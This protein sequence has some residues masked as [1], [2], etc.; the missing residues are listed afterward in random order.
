MILNK[1][2][3]FD[4]V[5]LHC[6]INGFRYTGELVK[7]LL[8]RLDEEE[9]EHLIPTMR[10]IDLWEET[11]EIIEKYQ[12]PRGR[13]EL[14]YKLD[15]LEEQICFI[16]QAIEQDLIPKRTWPPSEWEEVPF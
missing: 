4:A 9:D 5:R 2:Y 1:S 14:L 16:K 8:D 13:L 6:R 15:K 7:I 12:S 10:R 3:Y 11:Y